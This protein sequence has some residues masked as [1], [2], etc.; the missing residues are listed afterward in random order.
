MTENQKFNRWC[1]LQN[2]REKL[3]SVGAN[4]CFTYGELVELRQLELELGL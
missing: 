4:W 1:Q 2:Q 3:M